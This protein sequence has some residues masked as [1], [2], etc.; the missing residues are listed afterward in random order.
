MAL[1]VDIRG[2]LP[3]SEDKDKGSEWRWE[4]RGHVWE[5]K[6]EERREGKAVKM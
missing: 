3:F 5:R 1:R 4:W 6:C 2:R